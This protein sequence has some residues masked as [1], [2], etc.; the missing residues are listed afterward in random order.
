[1]LDPPKSGQREVAARSAAAARSRP[2]R[3]RPVAAA[4][5]SARQALATRAAEVMAALEAPAPP[6]RWARQD[7]AAAVDLV[8]R[9]LGP[10]HD[11]QML[12]ASYER[13]STRL[14]ALRRLAVDPAATPPPIDPTDAAYAVRWLE[15]RDAAGPLPAWRDLVT[16]GLR[17]D[18]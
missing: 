13:E 4:M 14:A 17:A 15:L 9:Q 5:P 7:F 6:A 16:G 2:R 18:G 3:P 1:M 12:V 11:R 8:R 10:L